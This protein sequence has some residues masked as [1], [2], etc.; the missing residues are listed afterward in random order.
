MSDTRTPTD[1]TAASSSTAAHG[2][3]GLRASFQKR[4]AAGDEFVLEVDFEA[5]AGFTIVFGASGAGKTTLL[6]C[7]AGLT[8]PDAGNVSI[9]GHA[10]FDSSKRINIPIAQRRTGYVLQSLALF[11]HMTVAQNVMYG[12]THLS[13]SDRRQRT[14]SIL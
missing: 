2:D 4:I 7:I 1:V 13:Q 6:D 11:P 3:V 14:E 9:G 10:V 12:L 8:K 5:P